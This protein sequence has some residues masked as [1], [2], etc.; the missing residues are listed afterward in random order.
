MKPQ[1]CPRC[2]SHNVSLQKRGNGSYITRC[3]D[4][5]AKW[6]GDQ[7]DVFQSE[8]MTCVMCGKVQIA[9]PDVES[10][11]RCI[12]MDEDKYYACTDHFPPDGS[13]KEAFTH[14]YMLVLLKIGQL[15]SK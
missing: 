10:N 7:P 13:P 12:Q 4:C 2:G 6:K 8:A 3:L 9:H 11:W 14:A 1:Q 5:R 15:R